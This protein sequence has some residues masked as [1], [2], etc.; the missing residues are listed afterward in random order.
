MEDNRKKY[1]RF[2]FHILG[3]AI[4]FLF[5]ATYEY[6]KHS[7]PD[8]ICMK[9][10]STQEINWNIP[11]SGAVFAD[12][13]QVVSFQRPVTIIT[14]SE[15]KTYALDLKLF[16]VVPLKKIDV[17][18]VKSK[19]L[20][21]LGSPIGIYMKTQGVLV[22]DTGSFLNANGQECSPAKNIISPGDYLI[23]MDGTAITGKNQVKDYIEAGKGKPISFQV[24]HGKEIKEVEI[25]PQKYNGMLYKAGMWLRDSAQGIGTITYIDEDLNFGA[26]GHGI[27]DI[28]VGEL[29]D[30]GSGLLYKTEIISIKKGSRGEPGEITGLILYEPNQIC[31]VITQNSNVG[32]YGSVSEEIYE[33]LK[34]EKIPIAFKQE[35]SLGPAKILCQLGS[36][37]KYYDI[38]ITGLDYN[39]SQIN[40]RIAFK[41]TDKEL[42]QLTGGIVQGMSGS[43]IIQ[44]GKII[45][46]VTHV[47][48]NDPTKGYGIF[49]ENMMEEYVN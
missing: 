3:F 30:L 10:D 38:N 44:N 31:G 47:F 46:A 41:V 6:Y 8:T 28:D 29:L 1:R 40:Q 2:L 32:I 16:G 24:K 7:V 43:P 13:S 49:I 4:V 5:F 12:S 21:P 33:K 34:N 19:E 37:R 15:E 20:I 18:I 25:T 27:N 23:A 9:T 26:L 35:V 45:G 48:I 36:Q 22:L 17:E 14:G 42:L 11:A 39:N